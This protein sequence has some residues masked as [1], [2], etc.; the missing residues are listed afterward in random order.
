MHDPVSDLLRDLLSGS[1]RSAGSGFLIEESAVPFL[2]DVYIPFGN[3]TFDT[4]NKKME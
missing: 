4:I 2:G 3:S 1:R